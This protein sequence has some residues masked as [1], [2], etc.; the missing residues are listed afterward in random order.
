MQSKTI[1]IGGMIGVGKS[2]LVS[3]LEDHFSGQAFYEDVSDNDLLNKFYQ[4][5][6][7]WSYTLQTSFLNKRFRQLQTAFN[8][9]SVS[10]LDRSFY[11][12]PLFALLNYERSNMSEEEFNLYLNLYQ[13]FKQQLNDSPDLFIYLSADFSSIKERILKRNRDFEDFT[14]KPELL[15]Y[16]KHLYSKYDNDW[17]QNN[18]NASKIYTLDTE[19]YNYLNKA[20]DRQE[21]LSHIKSLI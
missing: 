6:E 14:Q 20:A 4:N 10:I 9:S 11:E 16:L 7:R 21:V 15:D 2:T 3:L 19:Q 12:D 1:V 5:K 17:L 8:Q 18:Y 13:T